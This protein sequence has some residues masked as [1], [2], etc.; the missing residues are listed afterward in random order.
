MEQ[1]AQPSERTGNP[2]G[3]WRMAVIAFLGFNLAYGCFFGTLPVLLLSVEER[4]GTTREQVT[5]AFMAAAIA[6]ALLA[7][8]V[9]NLANRISIRT[10]FLVG[11]VLMCGGNILLAQAE[12]LTLFVALHALMIGPAN[13]ICGGVL[14]AVIVTRW[15]DN[16]R[17]KA[18][19]F[20]HTPI[21]L[22]IFPV[23][24]AQVL[25]NAGVEA[26]YYTAAGAAGLLFLC[27]M[28]VQDRKAPQGAEPQAAP[29]LESAP[30]VLR[31]PAFWALMIPAICLMGAMGTLGAHIVAI[32]DSWGIPP[33]RAAIFLTANSLAAIAGPVA[34]GL[35]SDRRGGAFS[36]TVIA[37]CSAALWATMLLEPGFA[38]M[39]AIIIGVGAI[40]GGMIPSLSTGLAQALGRDRFATAYGLSK[41]VP[42]PLTATAVPLAGLVF[43][44]TGSYASVIAF[45]AAVLVL[46]API[47]LMA[48]RA[49]PGASSGGLR[50]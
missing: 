13:V 21:I 29:L 47:A 4:L 3:A 9:G 1:Q 24:M 36:I 50:A 40:N 11:A 8:V 49:N 14:P 5:L 41:F 32:A 28:F 26:A 48:R 12:S 31:Q 19:G 17:G 2:P 15:F 20:A 25:A 23:V 16:G 38:F 43:T 35:L 39:L 10:I 27:G 7:P 45:V 6:G 37:L 34:F 18:L 30:A 42:L 46:V 33:Q 22:A 44:R